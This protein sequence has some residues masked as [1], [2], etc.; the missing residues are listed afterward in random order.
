MFAPPVDFNLAHHLLD[1]RVEEGNGQRTAIRTDHTTYTYA[2]VQ[3]RANRLAAALVE[4]GLAQEQ[5]VILALPDGLD[6]VAGL[7]AILKAGGVVVMINPDL[8]VADLEYF[9]EYSRAPLALVHSGQQETFA[10]AAARA[11]LL[12]A[13]QLP[14][15]AEFANRKTH[16]DDP[17]LWIFSGGTTGK[18]KA[19][20]QSHR[21]FANTTFHYGQQFLGLGPDDVTLA[22]PKLYFGYATGLNLFFPFSVGASCCLFEQPSTPE[23]IFERI[24]RHRPTLLVNVPK[25]IH[26]MAA[27]P[28]AQQHDLSCLRLCT[29]AGEAL[30]PA[31]YSLW[32]D[33]FGVELVD[34]LGTAEMWHIF[35]SNKPGQVKP[36]TLGQAVPGFTIKLA[37]DE[38]VPV[39]R[40]EL[41]RLWV[42]G[43]SRAICY[44]QRAEESHEAF[45]GPWFASGDKLYEDEDGYF[46]YCGRGDDMMKVG[47]K[48]LAPLEVEDCLLRHP[49][50]RECAVV[51]EIDEAGLTKPKAFV[52][53]AENSEGLAEELKAHTLEHLEAYKHPRSIVF[54]DEMPRTHL[55]KIDRARLKAMA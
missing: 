5:R 53:A 10:S 50:V 46:V 31:L 3:A 41:G 44:W 19:A 11:R 54:V 35:L 29:S 17:A 18:P 39:P 20:V 47:G 43:D 25:I 24:D 52:L 7:F 8:P 4:A 42:R 14:G 33:T 45:R 21:S 16:R 27:H 48:W 1:A 36:G 23:A 26:R 40:G 13:D 49:A 34:G 12:A 15:E 55:G 51:P 30:P 32:V 2:Q 22:I 6:F 37:D 9:F 38:G 28:Q